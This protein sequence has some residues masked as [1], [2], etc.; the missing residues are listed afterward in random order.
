MP[1]KVFV[2]F[3]QTAP[4]MYYNTIKLMLTLRTKKCRNQTIQSVLEKNQLPGSFSPIGFGGN[5][6]FVKIDTF[7]QF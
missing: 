3:L 1:D 5:D 4:T 7:F 6:Y 2:L